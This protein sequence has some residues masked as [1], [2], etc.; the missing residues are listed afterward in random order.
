MTFDSWT[1]RLSIILRGYRARSAQP[2]VLIA[3]LLVCLGFASGQRCVAHEIA[4]KQTADG[5]Q[6]LR[7]GQP[8]YVRGAGGLGSLAGL[9]AAGANS[10]RT[11]GVG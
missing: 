7:D 10:N 11:W 5:W 2:T 3:A 6:L 8:Y 9:S 1:T 4:L